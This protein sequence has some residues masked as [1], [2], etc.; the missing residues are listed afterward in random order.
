MYLRHRPL[1]VKLGKPGTET[2]A[3]AWGHCNTD[4]GLQ[5]FLSN[6]TKRNRNLIGYQLS[7][8]S[9]QLSAISYQLSAISYQRF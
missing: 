6:L 9:Y 7:A 5:I 1:G 2:E 3:L 8:I 4:W